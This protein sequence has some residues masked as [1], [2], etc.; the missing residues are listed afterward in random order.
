MEN[1][2]KIT[3]IHFPT[4]IGL[5]I[6]LVGVGV[7]IF[8]IK[9][10]TGTETG[11]ANENVTPAQVKITNVSDNSFSVSFITA[12]ASS[13]KIKY[14]IESNS[15]KQSVLDDRDQLSGETGVFEVHHITAKNLTAQTKYYFKI[16]SGGKQFDNQGKPFEITTGTTLGNPP[17]ADPVY[18]TILSP[19]GTP[20]EGVVVYLSVANGAPLSALSRT[21]GN[22]AISLSTARTAD[23][24][25]YLTYDMQAT[26]V[27]ILAQGGKAGTAPVITTT[28]NDSPVPEIILGKSQD[29]R[30]TANNETASASGQIATN[31]QSP[32]SGFEAAINLATTSAE[33]SNSGEVT[34]ANPSYNGEIINA[35]QPAFIGSGPPGKV[36]AIEVN[37]ETTYTGSAVVGQ[38]GEW[39]FTPPAGL[40]S[41]QHSVTISYIDT[42]GEE[43]NLTRSFVIAAA[44]ETDVPA[45]TATNSGTVATNTANTAR[46]QM[47]S[48]SSGVPHPGTG[49]TT[50]IIVVAGAGLVI[51][52]LKLKKSV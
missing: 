19:S 16:E 28:T 11:T 2:I 3:K 23:L 4:A 7:G 27:N 42:D 10:R 9:T 29:F 52:G 32:E 15:L 46:T 44:G 45:I 12:K 22:W 47:P 1:K 25:S 17:A 34:L 30:N 8:F 39:E 33:A 49:E 36:L 14:G 37:S 31:N 41:G 38:N 51:A 35:T 40:T 21:N 24:K 18:G 20:I 50:L 48:T 26:I 43:R 5:L 6:L 13:G